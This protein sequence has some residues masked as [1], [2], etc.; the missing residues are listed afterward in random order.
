MPILFW[1]C[2]A[3]ISWSYVGYPLMLLLWSGLGDALG[4]LRFVGGGPDR[5]AAV[6]PG[7]PWPRLS[8][9]FSAY[10][11]E[12]CIRRK[13]ENCLSLDYPPDRL[14]ILV[15]CDGCTDRTAQVAREAG[16]RRVTVHELFPRAGKASVLSRLVPQAQGDLVVLTDANVMLEPGAVKALVRR[17]RDGA[18]GAVVGR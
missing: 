16:G 8:I 13:I 12:A 5:R 10:D 15:G 2:L 7:Q 3:A 18:V 4:A 17:F 11:E 14:E 6:A 1:L 9:V